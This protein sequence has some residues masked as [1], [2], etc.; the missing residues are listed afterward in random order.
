MTQ[1]TIMKFKL[2]HIIL[3]VLLSSCAGGRKQ[4][5]DVE[6]M[7]LKGKVKTMAEYS[8]EAEEKFGEI[9]KG[10]RL[11]ETKNYHFDPAYSFDERGMIKEVVAYTVNSSIAE[12]TINKY[13]GNGHLIESSSYNF[14]GSLRSR[15]T[16]TYNNQGL[17]V[18]EGNYDAIGTISQKSIY[19]Y[20]NNKNLI[21]AIGY[22]KSGTQ[23]YKQIMKYNNKNQMIENVFYDPQN[24]LLTKITYVNDEQGNWLT[25]NEFTNSGFQSKKFAYTYD[26]TGNEIETNELQEWENEPEKK[27]NIKRTNKYDNNNNITEYKWFNEDGSLGGTFIYKYDYDA[28]GNWIKKVEIENNVAKLIVERNI[29]YY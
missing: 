5:S 19:K 3:L 17:K 15:Q 6:E 14:N 1:L 26:N 13:D 2:S 4:K 22:N 16:N 29:E 10:K 23:D 18:E 21:E 28:K 8:Y 11:V 12:K 9:Q 24:K 27:S 20:D 25:Y 7:K